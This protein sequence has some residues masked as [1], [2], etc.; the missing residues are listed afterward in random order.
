[1]INMETLAKIEYNARHKFRRS[2]VDWGHIFTSTYATPRRAIEIPTMVQK[3]PMYMRRVI[4][5]PSFPLQF[6]RRAPYNRTR[7]VLVSRRLREPS[8][9]SS[10]F[11]KQFV[12]IQIQIPFPMTPPYVAKGLPAVLWVC[13]SIHQRI[14]QPQVPPRISC[15]FES[16]SR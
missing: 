7:T 14:S 5:N 3:R 13:P 15:T 16:L 1:M 2:M 12:M 8:T 11:S 4:Q 10:H 9:F 6:G